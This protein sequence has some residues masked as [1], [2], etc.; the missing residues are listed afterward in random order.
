MRRQSGTKGHEAPSLQ[1]K[2]ECLAY[3]AVSNQIIHLWLLRLTPYLA[4]VS[5]PLFTS[6][7]LREWRR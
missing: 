2:T 6:P 3:T 1:E 4:N 7:L 5:K